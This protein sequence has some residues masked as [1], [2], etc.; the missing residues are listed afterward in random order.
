MHHSHTDI[1]YSHLQEEVEKIHV[2]N[3]YQALHM[4]EKTSSYPLESRFK[5]NIESSWAAENFLKT[6]NESDK[7]KFFR[8]LRN[9]SIALAG[10][11]SNEL[12]GISTPE[13]IS[14]NYDYASKLGKQ[15]QFP[16]VTGMMTDIPGMSWSAV[17]SMAQ[18]GI[19]Y[20]SD[21]PNYMDNM[22]DL[23]DRIGHTIRAL[24]DK[25]FWWKS[26]D[27]KD[28]LLFWVV[29][30]G[31]SSWHGFAPGA[32]FER[33]AEKIAQYMNQLKDNAYPYTTVQWRYNI[34]S[35]N[36]PIDSTI[37]DFVKDWNQR[38]VSPK[39]ILANVNDL[40]EKFEKDYG[41]T[42][43]VLAGDFTGYWEDGAYSTAQEENE[44]KELSHKILSIE[45]FCIQNKQVLNQDWLYQAKKFVMLFQEHTWGSWNS[46]S[47]PENSFTIHQWEFKKHYIDSLQKYV[48]LLENELQPAIKATKSIA[49]VNVLPWNRTAY[50]EINAKNLNG[51]ASLTDEKDRPVAVQQLKNGNWLFLAENIPANGQTK[52]NFISKNTNPDHQNQYVFSWS[53][54]EKTGALAQVKSGTQEWVDPS[55]WGGLIQAIYV[56]G[57]NPKDCTF[58]KIKKTEWLEKGPLY[59]KCKLTA[60]LEG[61]NEIIYYVEEFAGLKQLKL[62][63]AVDKQAVQTKES[64]HFAFPFQLKNPKVRIG[65]DSTFISPD[66]GQIPGSNKDFFCA[67]RWIDI[68]ETAKGVTLSSPQGTLYEVG[69][70]IDEQRINNGYK[71]W[72]TTASS[73]NVVFLYAMNNYWHTNYKAD[74]TGIAT[75]EFNLD[76]HQEFKLDEALRKGYETTQ[77]LMVIYR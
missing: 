72:K 29:G 22:P 35:D 31:Y 13:E 54:N 38:Y 55:Q 16:V 59:R 32:V 60:S 8:A 67:Q 17:K 58:S 56:K 2:N 64:L 15:H 25:P 1:G 52:Y 28:S 51:Y 68:S 14:W 30:K 23:G 18:H 42:L 75:F 63:V 11:Y 57:L 69:S 71:K 3:I 33:G 41:K 61:C 37:S 10:T 34:V 27:D 53:P 47:D 44:V 70:L 5:W 12:T 43:P 76:F 74:Q 49:V 62:T 45:K 7:N 21:G 50:V 36:G 26:S 48:R 39:L 77:P 65:I 19:R 66:A 46:I 20:F 9:H 40:F 73:S 6:A 4:I 24:G